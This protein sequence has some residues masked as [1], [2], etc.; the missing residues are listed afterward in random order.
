ML[1]VGYLALREW[2]DEKIVVMAGYDHIG[3]ARKL[4]DGGCG[5]FEIGGVEETLTWHQGAGA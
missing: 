3:Q 5:Q 2:A 4:V 1:S